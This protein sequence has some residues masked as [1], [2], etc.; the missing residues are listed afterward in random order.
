MPEAAQLAIVAPFAATVIAV[1]HQLDESVAPGTA[2]IV[3]EAMKMEHEVVAEQGGVVRRIDVSVGDNVT[4]GQLLAVLEAGDSGPDG[5][6]SGDRP[7]DPDAP[8]EDLAAVRRRHAIGLDPARPDAVDKRHQRG[9]RTA[10]ENLD[11]LVDEGTFVEY[12]PLIFAAQERRRAKQ[13]LIERT[14]ADGLVGG[15]GEIDSRPAVV[16]SYD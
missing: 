10:R 2:L 16:M 15:V 13:E 3:L 8:R 4:E 1:A 9:H 11:D 5:D 6:R 7:A 12:G 14:P